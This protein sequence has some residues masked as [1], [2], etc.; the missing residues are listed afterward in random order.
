M[1][2]KICSVPYLWLARSE[3]EQ[4]LWRGGRVSGLTRRQPS[5]GLWWRYLWR[6]PDG[7]WPDVRWGF[8]L[9]APLALLLWV[10]SADVMPR[11]RDLITVRAESRVT[12]EGI[13]NAMVTV[14]ETRYR[15]S[16]VGEIRI[17]PVLAG[18]DVTVAAAGYETMHSEVAEAA[19]NDIVVSLTGVLV[20]GTITDAL[21][22][23]PVEGAELVVHDGSGTPVATNRT[24]EAGSFV[25]KL[26]P[27]D[28]TVRIHHDVYGEVIH[29]LGSRRSLSIRL[30]P[31]P[32]TGRVV[33]G[34]G[35]PIAGVRITGPNL[36]AVGEVDGSF[37]L[38][39][40][41]QGSEIT[42]SASNGQSR[43]VT[44]DGTDL[45]DIVVPDEAATP[46]GGE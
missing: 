12:G 22:G 33:N 39:P 26:I 11:D 42:L 31:P 8:S 45:G 35:E 17:E 7:R 24:D 34:A 40:I 28:A 41:G 15:T 30:E 5:L 18:T 38:H 9:L 23:S 1:S 43:T 32:V 21:S 36:E 29:V 10:V 25:F 3:S 19:D 16:D 46:E 44:V 4:G 13:A 6:T 20:L 2:T 14:G 37:R 27:E